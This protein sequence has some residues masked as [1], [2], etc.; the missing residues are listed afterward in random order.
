MEPRR[1]FAS[2]YR[3]SAIARQVSCRAQKAKCDVN[4]LSQRHLN[5]A[6]VL[7][8]SAGLKGLGPIENVHSHQRVKESHTSIWMELQIEQNGLRGARSESITW[9]GCAARGG[10]EANPR[11]PVEEERDTALPQPPAA[12]AHG[13]TADR[14]GCRNGKPPPPLSTLAADAGAAAPAAPV[15]VRAGRS[16]AAACSAT[17]SR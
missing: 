3:C 15:K 11:A 12:V 8:T 16:P 14:A 1:Q 6:R 17:D 4:D 2:E 5:A 10:P 9:N 7:R 13:S